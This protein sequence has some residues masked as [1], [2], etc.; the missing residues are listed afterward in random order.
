MNL[1]PEEVLANEEEKQK[2]SDIEQTTNNI[3][4]A[5]FNIEIEQAILGALLVNNEYY[6][7]I[8]HIL[9]PNFFYEKLHQ[10]I[11]SICSKLIQADRRADYKTVKSYLPSNLL[12]S[13]ELP[14]S[15]Y[16][17]NL[18]LDTVAIINIKDY[19]Q[20][21]YELYLRRQLINIG[22]DIVNTAYEVEID[23]PP[24][25]QIAQAELKLFNLAEHNAPE[26]GPQ[27]ISI[28]LTESIA[29]AE[30]AHKRTGHLS[31]IATGLSDLDKLMGGLQKS[32]LIILAGRPGMGKTSLATN[33]AFNISY[34]K[35]NKLETNGNILFFSLEMSS[36]QLAT[37][38]ISEQSEISSANIRRGNLTDIELDRLIK[39]S[40]ELQELPLYIDPTGGIS[41]S[42][43]SARARRHK[44]QF[45]LDVI[46]IDYIQLMTVANSSSSNNR[47]AEITEI[48]NSLKALAKE[49]NV[50]II[51]L[52]QLSRQ[53]ENREDKRPQLSDLRESGSIEQDADV[54]LFVYRDEYYLQNTEPELDSSKYT[55]WQT[56]MNASKGKA[57]VIIAKQRHG[58]TG[59][60]KLQ[61][62]S[63]Y[64]RFSNLAEDNN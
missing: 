30:A 28:A 10:K 37:R 11:Y 56:K 16:L 24:V 51:A 13:D 21:I 44:R 34:A 38:I 4:E 55:E 31:G 2:T 32:D 57:D 9:E 17:V 40:R 63:R 59:T 22:E 23:I 41:S 43:L 64:T 62:E 20:I 6:D 18:C 14:I 61:F 45:G 3:R 54:V 33:I 58:P 12:V 35:K 39:C 48:T 5:P 8:S 60:V 52:S 7:K 19:A 25:E 42:K 49:L 1:S 50:P 53:V 15:E 46:V 29:M 47:V 36:E 26:Q 27:P